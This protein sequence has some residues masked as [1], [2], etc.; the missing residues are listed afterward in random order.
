MSH[1]ILIKT[2]SLGF[3]LLSPIS[4]ASAF[5][6][7]S[8]TELFENIAKDKKGSIKAQNVTGFIV[9]QANKKIPCK[10][11]YYS[12]FNYGEF[13][14]S[15]NNGAFITS[16]WNED[17]SQGGYKNIIILTDKNKNE[18]KM[19]PIN[20]NFTYTCFPKTVVADTTVTAFQTALHFEIFIQAI[21]ERRLIPS[22][23]GFD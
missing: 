4:A 15:C 16:F 9:T 7:C 6:N 21:Y 23:V 14:L 1:N 10:V 13:E 8:S 17:C 12:Y 20:S 11:T 22:P 3:I 19:I 2:I 18:Y 5:N